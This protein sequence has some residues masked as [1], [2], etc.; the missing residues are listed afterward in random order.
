MLNYLLSVIGYEQVW[1]VSWIAIKLGG[2]KS[3]ADAVVTILP[4][5]TEK[6]I[7]VLRKGLAEKTSDAIGESVTAE[8]IN[9]VSMTRIGR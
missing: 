2:E 6:S 7:I 3:Y 1:H 8:Q 4:R 9:I 5:L